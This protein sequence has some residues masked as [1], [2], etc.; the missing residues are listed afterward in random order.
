MHVC[1]VC[2]YHLCL[3]YD[4][5]MEKKPGQGEIKQPLVRLNFMNIDFLI[6]IHHH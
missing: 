5:E 3:A 4:I 6:T 1:D 2:C